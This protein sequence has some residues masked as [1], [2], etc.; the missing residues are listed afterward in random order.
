MASAGAFPRGAPVRHAAPYPMKRGSA[1]A[2]VNDSP[3]SSDPGFRWAAE[4]CPADAAAVAVMATAI[5]AT[6]RSAPFLIS[7]TPLCEVHTAAPAT[8]IM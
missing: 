7:P 4:T 1:R 6:T 8:V 3:T 2:P 5:D